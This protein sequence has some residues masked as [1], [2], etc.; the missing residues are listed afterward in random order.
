MTLIQ[1]SSRTVQNPSRTVVLPAASRVGL[2]T[3]YPP[4]RCGIGKFS[5]SLVRGLEIVAPEI[6]VEV[7]RL[8][9]RSPTEPASGR[10]T[11]EIIPDLPIAIRAAARRLNDCDVVLLQ[12]EYAIYG[13]N[14]GEAILDLIDKIHR[15]MVVVLHTVLSEP[16]ERQKSIIEAI[17]DQCQLVVLSDSARRI[18]ADR[19]PVDPGKVAMIPHGAR[20][21]PRPINRPPRRNL[22]TWGLL[23]PGKGLERAISALPLL[24]HL[25]PLPLYRIVGRTHPAVAR[26]SG[27]AY[28]RR[29]EAL[30]RELGVE[31]MVEFLDTYMEEDELERLVAE[32]D[33]VVIPYDSHDQ[34]SSGVLTEAVAAG[35]PVVATRFPHAVELLG[36]G[37]GLTVSHDSEAMAGAIARL[38]EDSNAYKSCAMAAGFRA[39]QLSWETSCREYI[40]LAYRLLDEDVAVESVDA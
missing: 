6:E 37:A 3:T 28:R 7:V 4:T 19:Y 39:R 15:P 8:I 30:A 35:R 22:I 12:H 34:I 29:L 9:D 38:L 31:D 40:R 27:L 24:R 11:L 32:S 10:A 5:D 2:V 13:G 16:S 14:D 33:V 20:W 18:L 21:A 17:G 23:G 25:R 36:G 1:N 26:K